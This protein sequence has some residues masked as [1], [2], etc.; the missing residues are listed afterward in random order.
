MVYDAAQPRWVRWRFDGQSWIELTPPPS[1]SPSNNT[2]MLASVSGGSHVN[3][4]RN[5]FY[6]RSIATAPTA[7]AEVVPSVTVVPAVVSAGQRVTATYHGAPDTVLTIYSKTQPATTYS[8]IGSVTLDSSGRGTSTHA[9]HRNTRIMAGTTAGTMSAQPLIQVRSVASL[10]ATRLR[11]RTYRFSGTVSPALANRLVNVY[12]NGALVAQGRTS[13][14][15]VYAITKALAA[16]TYGFVVR[17]PND[18]YNLGATSRT[19]LLR[20]S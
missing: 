9:P 10:N 17:T 14:T 6:D 20:V 18:T 2:L 19:L 11:T 7:P 4:V 15:G 3:L 1:I 13:S 16:G 12:R 5:G 8:R